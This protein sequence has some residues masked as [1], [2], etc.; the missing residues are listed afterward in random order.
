MIE[1]AFDMSVYETAEGDPAIQICVNL[2]EGTL[3]RDVVVDVNNVLGVG[4]A[5]CKH[6]HI[7]GHMHC[8]H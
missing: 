2:I 4:T 5:T 3:T 8:V 1:F 7:V 6:I